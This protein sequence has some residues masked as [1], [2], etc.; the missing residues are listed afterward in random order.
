MNATL[1]CSAFFLASCAQEPTLSRRAIVGGVTEPGHPYV[2]AV[3]ANFA[4]CS[5][6]LISART[7]LTAGHCSGHH[8]RLL[9]P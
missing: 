6:T 2:V 3:G 9:W 7:V 1:W 5:G 8:S 4:F